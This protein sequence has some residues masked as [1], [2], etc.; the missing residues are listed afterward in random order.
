MLKVH[1]DA[2]SQ[3]ILATWKR[4]RQR[5]KYASAALCLGFLT[6]QMLLCLLGFAACEPTYL[7]VAKLF[8]SVN[9]NEF[10]HCVTESALYVSKY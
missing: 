7:C 8:C 10:T 9:I 1:Q 6:V 4:E 3:Q 5:L 2:E